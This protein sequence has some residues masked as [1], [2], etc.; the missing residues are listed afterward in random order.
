[1]LQIALKAV[2]SLSSETTKQTN[3]SSNTSS[4]CKH[5]EKPLSA[6]P[7]KML[8]IA[9][10]NPLLYYLAV[11]G[12]LMSMAAYTMIFW[13][14]IVINGLLRGEA[15]TNLQVAAVKGASKSQVR[16]LGS[17]YLQGSV[18]SVF[19]KDKS[20]ALA[21]LQVRQPGV[22]LSNQSINQNAIPAMPMGKQT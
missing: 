6:Q 21:S 11:C 5:C 2:D 9:L 18:G 4:T 3:Q 15:L 20:V 10:R 14:P 12:F 17:V 8:H 16:L 1:M 19:S 13:L 22:V 7:L